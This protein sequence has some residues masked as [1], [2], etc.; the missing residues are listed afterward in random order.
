MLHR[1]KKGGIY[2][3]KK[4]I[5]TCFRNLTRTVLPHVPKVPVFSWMLVALRISVNILEY[6]SALALER[7]DGKFVLD[8]LL[9]QS[10]AFRNQQPCLDHLFFIIFFDFAK[11]HQH[12]AA[13]R[14]PSL[15]NICTL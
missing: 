6:I 1:T 14:C 15:V 12:M 2:A 10:S 8:S 5:R 13:G 7:D 4:S 9:F 11:Y 3:L